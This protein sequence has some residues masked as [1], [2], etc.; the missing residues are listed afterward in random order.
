MLMLTN[1]ERWWLRG[2][3]A[4]IIA[5][6]V[7]GFV[8]IQ[9]QN[10]KPLPTPK[11]HPSAPCPEE[12]VKGGGCCLGS[13]TRPLPASDWIATPLWE[14]RVPPPPPPLPPVE[15]LLPTPVYSGNIEMDR[16]TVTWK[17]LP[18]D[19][20][21]VEGMKRERSAVAAIVVHRRCDEG[22]VEVIIL[23]PKATSFTDRGVLPGRSYRYSVFV[24]GDEGIKRA[25]NPTLRTIDKDGEGMAEGRVPE[26]HR[27]TLLGGDREHAIF[28][29]ESY[30]PMK[31]KW[32]SKVLQGS[33]GK[34]IGATGWTL[35]GMRFDKFTLQAVLVDERLERREISTKKK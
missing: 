9:A 30:N 35:E 1:A 29:V 13:P 28:E 34:G 20:K 27:I 19:L 8:E 2:A 15:W 31:S 33:P 4:L 26:W 32:E 5:C 23:E 25:I 6:G 14:I 24:R 3:W 16:A 10:S 11:I 12:S 18:P 21:P 7:G 22:E 17:L